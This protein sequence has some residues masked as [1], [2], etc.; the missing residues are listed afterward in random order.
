M[1]RNWRVLAF[2]VALL[3][4][5]GFR[6]QQEPT[7]A[8]AFMNLGHFHR[9]VTTSSPEAQRWFDQGLTLYWGF[10]HEAAIAAYKQAL[11]LDPDCAAAYWGIALALGPHINNPHL[12]EAA[13]KAA[14]AAEQVALAHIDHGSPVEQDLIRALA[15]RYAD[16]PPA[17]RA[18]LDKAFA[19]AMRRVWRDHPDDPDVGT[20]AAESLMDLRPWDLWSPEGE[21]RPETPEVMADLE[22]VM[23]IAPDHPGANHFYVHTMEASPDPGKALTAANR[24][25][26][27]V[28]DCSH[29]VHMP[30][31]IDIRLGRYADAIAANQ[32]AI[33]A[34][35]LYVSRFGRNNFYALYRAHNFHFLAWAAMFA[36]QRKLAMDAA[37]GV[38]QEIPLDLARQMPDFLDA[39]MAAP[40]C[41]LVRFGLWQDMLNEK[42]PPAGLPVTA[43]YW[44]FG[45]TVALAALGRV[46]EAAKEREA[47]EAACA[48]V[49]E[50]AMFGNNSARTVLDIGRPF[51]EGELEYR[52]GNVDKAFALL[53][54]SVRRDD[55]LRYDE[56]WG[57]MEPVRHA[58]GALQLEQGRLADA[59]ATY[60]ADLK[61]HPDNGWAL[62][63][64][65]EC[66]RRTGRMAEAAAT[67]ARFKQAWSGADVAIK[68]SC[69]CRTKM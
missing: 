18:P 12:D 69:Y 24:L 1:H 56:P 34:D 7:G 16:P 42:E 27:L 15:T 17:D 19:D 29:L 10:S 8:P 58:L 3:A 11:A 53:A 20:L 52:R 31:H 25:R 62:Q 41:V 57:W 44:R 23:A 5:T 35:K 26:D 60:Q 59:E 50:S 2:A 66:Q 49:P 63:G 21:P 13:S 4:L 39:F 6:S 30:A 65:E 14:Y 32:K 33:A 68:A 28:P 51:A 45:R 43:A 38:L 40:Y 47:F 67:E 36:G 37:Q 46:D 9:S 54:E 55:A 64:L 22:R 48:R 61:Q